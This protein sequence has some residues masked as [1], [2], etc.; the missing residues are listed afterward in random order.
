MFGLYVHIPVCRH[1]C[2]YCDFF[3]MVVSNNYQDKV[4][5]AI[6][7][8]LDEKKVVTTIDTVYIGGGTPSCLTSNNLDRILSSINN[9]LLRT[10]NNLDVLEYTIELNPEDIDIDLIK[11]LKK[12]PINRISIG[13]Q[14]FNMDVQKVLERKSDFED[15]KNKIELLKENGYNNI[16]L[17]YIYSAVPSNVYTI[18][19]QKEDLELFLSLKPTHLSCYS[20]IV[21]EKTILGKKALD[22]LYVRPDENDDLNQY[23][24]MRKMLKEQGFNQYEISNYASSE[25]FESLHNKIYW[26]NECYAGIGPYAS[27]YEIKD[28]KHIRYT[29]SRSLEDYSSAKLIE[30]EVLTREDI[31]MYE[32]ILGLRLTKGIDMNKFNIKY[33]IS[34]LKSFPKINELISKGILIKENDY[35]FVNEKQLYV[36]DYILKEIL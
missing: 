15:I 33:G 29:N 32:V 1:I 13:V 16:N 19:K 5:N 28:G 9:L 22:G 4:I 24:I 34:I 12:Y 30:E 6:C 10:N 36:L 8:E 20:L 23:H 3:K 26:H 11:L 7:R 18:E 27:G 25:K 2:A 21:E 31:I 17:D 35:L 14:S